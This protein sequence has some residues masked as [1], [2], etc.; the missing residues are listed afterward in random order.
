MA[1]K[2]VGKLIEKQGAQTGASFARLLGLSPAQWSRIRNGKQQLTTRS[3]RATLALWPEL[4][5]YLA[6]DAKA[7]QTPPAA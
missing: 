3:I 7:S 6:E 2:L 5:Y 4:A 1:R